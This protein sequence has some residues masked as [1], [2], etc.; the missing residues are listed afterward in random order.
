ML[1]SCTRNLKI[2]RPDQPDIWKVNVGYVTPVLPM[3]KKKGLTICI[4]WTANTLQNT[5]ALPR[6]YMKLV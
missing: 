5:E 3:A 1:A 6:T 2:T 4:L